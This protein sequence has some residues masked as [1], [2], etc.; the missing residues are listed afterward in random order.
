MNQYPR[1]LTL[2]EIKEQ[3]PSLLQLQQE[4]TERGLYAEINVQQLGDDHFKANVSVDGPADEVKAVIDALNEM[5]P[6][7]F[8]VIRSSIE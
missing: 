4:F 1:H 7:G 5:P 6:G 8:T 3:F 2:T